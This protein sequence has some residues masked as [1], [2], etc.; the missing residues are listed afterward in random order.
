MDEF[1]LIRRFFDRDQP[2]VDI[3]IGD[4]AAVVTVP[5]GQQ[6]V[7][8]VDTL[9]GGVHFPD[10]M[11]PADVGYRALAVNLSDLAA[12]GA[13]PRWAT[14]A[15]TLPDADPEWLTGFAAGL[16]D[17][18][19]ASGVS[20]IGGDTTRGPLTVSVQALGLVPEGSALRR[21]G[22]RAGDVIAVTGTR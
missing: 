10:N 3:G 5:A 15:L 4:D 14:L 22:A 6:L 11:S 13:S 8:A 16:F 17:L 7:V 1:E 19:D 2:A 9:V 18:C 12:M 21:N 20:L